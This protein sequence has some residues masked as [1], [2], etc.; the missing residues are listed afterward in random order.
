V[1][2]Y[3]QALANT[4]EYA[5]VPSVGGYIMSSDDHH[6][7]CGIDDFPALNNSFSTI[8][9]MEKN[10]EESECLMDQT[11]KVLLLSSNSFRFAFNFGLQIANASGGVLQVIV[12]GVAATSF[13]S[14]PTSIKLLRYGW[15]IR[16]VIA[17][18]ICFIPWNQ[19]INNKHLQSVNTFMMLFQ[20]VFRAAGYIPLALLDILPKN[21]TEVA[22]IAKAIAATLPQVPQAM[23][24]DFT[25]VE[26]IW[27]SVVENA[28]RTEIEFYPLY[29]ENLKQMYNQIDLHSN[30]SSLN[31]HILPP[32][33]TYYYLKENVTVADVP[34]FL[35]NV[36]FR[37]EIIAFS[38]QSV[39]FPSIL[40]LPAFQRGAH[41]AKEIVPQSVV[42]GWLAY[43]TQRLYLPTNLAYIMVLQ[44]VF[45]SEYLLVVAFCWMLQMFLKYFHHQDSDWYLM[46]YSTR[47]QFKAADKNDKGMLVKVL[48]WLLGTMEY[49]FMVLF[50]TYSLPKYF[51]TIVTNYLPNMVRAPV[52]YF[53][54]RMIVTDYLLM[55]VARTHEPSVEMYRAIE[56]EN[57]GLVFLDKLK[58]LD[59]TSAPSPLGLSLISAA[60]PVDLGSTSGLVSKGAQRT[61]YPMVELRKSST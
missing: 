26:Q 7:C 17:V 18:L 29:L 8:F 53:I 2:W 41:L 39:F 48:G 42:C 56:K 16:I 11:N 45:Q 57:D 44:Q 21:G 59:S 55:T 4:P 61:S 52:D 1:T 60:S 49:V 13:V 58:S 32:D 47:R 51:Q 23:N 10:V 36:Y 35:Q 22:M 28:T 50:F 3:S 27:P 31:Q 20:S 33:L 43:T 19:L 38:I 6:S 12:Y 15:S 46:P 54:Q 24:Q 25:W 14:F 34:E 5:C 40:L 37:Y 9:D 30:L